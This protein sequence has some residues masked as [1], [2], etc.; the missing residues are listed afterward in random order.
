MTR[1]RERRGRRGVL[2]NDHS[3]P[4]LGAIGFDEGEH[5]AV[6]RVKNEVKATLKCGN[7]AIA[8]SGGEPENGR[9]SQLRRSC[10][11]C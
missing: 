8:D 7:V 4:G 6:N 3:H 10:C 1:D 9:L 11:Y 2:F 5:G